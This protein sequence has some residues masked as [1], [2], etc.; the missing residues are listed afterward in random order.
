M[1]RISIEEL[2]QK[3]DSGADIL[4]VD[5]RKPEEYAKDWIKGAVSVPLDVIVAG[6]WVPPQDKEIIFYCA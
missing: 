2:R 1:P 5:T 3:M 6:Q 4:L